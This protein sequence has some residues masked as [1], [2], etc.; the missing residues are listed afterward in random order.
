MSAFLPQIEG[1]QV[2]KTR[3]WYVYVLYIQLQLNVL[4]GDPQMKMRNV[5]VARYV[6]RSA[7]AGSGQGGL[8]GTS[9]EL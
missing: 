2:R 5:F 6:G 1:K 9:G 4:G 3:W 8:N 7:I